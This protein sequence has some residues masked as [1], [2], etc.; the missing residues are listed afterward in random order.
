MH[1]TQIL[2]RSISQKSAEVV[3]VACC[4]GVE[5][6]ANPSCV[7]MDE[8]TSGALPL[9]RLCSCI[10]PAQ[11]RRV[12]CFCMEPSSSVCCSLWQQQPGSSFRDNLHLGYTAQQQR[13]N[14]CTAA[15]HQL[16][17]VMVAPLSTRVC[18]AH[19]PHCSLVGI[20]RYMA[21]V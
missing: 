5:L 17:P 8:P 7:F 11:L 19:T 18:G 3:S 6:V 1:F 21:C 16:A 4:A 15:A 2:H 14:F 10:A 12:G 20:R 9:N 13:V